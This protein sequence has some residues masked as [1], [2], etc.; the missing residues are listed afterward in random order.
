MRVL[1]VSGD[2]QR[3]A[4][5]A[6]APVHHVAR[7][8]HVCAGLGVRQRLLDQRFDGDVVHDVAARIDDPVLTM[9]RE[10]IER[11]VGDHAELRHS[12]L[13]GADCSLRETFGIP[14]FAPV[15]ALRFGRR[16]RKQRQ[17]RHA[18]PRQRL[19]LAHQLDRC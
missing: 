11:D 7:R 9:R 17:R 16:H 3:F 10:W 4:D 14:G 18:E 2:L 8:D 1:R 5:R 15:I 19:R 6:D 12:L 13:D